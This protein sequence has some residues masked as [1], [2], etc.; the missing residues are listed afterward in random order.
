MMEYIVVA[1]GTLENGDLWKGHLG[2]SEYFN[3]YKIFPD[4]SYKFIER[5]KNIKKDEEEKHGS[6]D[7][8]QGIKGILSDC[9]CVAASSL[10]PNFKKMAENTEIQPIVVKS[11]DKAEDFIQK[12]GYNYAVLN[13]KV[14][15]RKAG[16]RDA[17]IPVL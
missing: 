12:I 11:C 8:M 10:S 2:D 16:G 17:N 3:K 5:I 7:K 15:N 13:E 14:S 9:D 6:S 4:G 1:F